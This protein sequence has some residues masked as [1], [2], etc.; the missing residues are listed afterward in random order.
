MLRILGKASSINVRKVLWTCEETGTLFR[1]ED[2]GSGFQPLSTPDFLA[3]NPNALVPVIIDG[4]FVLWGSNA[5]CRYLVRRADRHDL[6]PMTI[7]ALAEVEKWMD[8]QETEF[9]SAWRYAFMAL[10]RKDPAFTSPDGVATSIVAWNRCAA[11]LDEQLAR[12]ALW[13]CGEDF[14]LADIV[15]GLS[16]NRWKMT[17]FEKPHLPALETWFTRLTEREGFRLYGDNGIP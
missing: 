11:I 15:L 5:I 7:T 2:Y 8:W 12:T 17:P 1:R 10:V 3:L 6:L 16:V 14:T 9:N 13:V 4:G